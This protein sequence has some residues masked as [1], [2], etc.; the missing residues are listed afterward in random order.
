MKP[1]MRTTCRPAFNVM[2]PSARRLAGP[3]TKVPE[4][5]ILIGQAVMVNTH[6]ISL[7][8]IVVCRLSLTARANAV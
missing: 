6:V 8:I 1:T 5:T 3:W 2:R 4:L 7:V